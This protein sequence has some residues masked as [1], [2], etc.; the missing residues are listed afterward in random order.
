MGWRHRWTDC[1]VGT[2]II[3]R[4]LCL[5][6]IHTWL[7]CC[8]SLCSDMWRTLYSR[9][10]EK[11]NRTCTNICTARPP[12]L[13]TSRGWG[14]AK[15]TAHVS[16]AAQSSEKAGP[17]GRFN[18]HAAWY[19]TLSVTM[20]MAHGGID[21]WSKSRK[22]SAVSTLTLSRLRRLSINLEITARWW[23]VRARSSSRA[24]ARF[25]LLEQRVISRSPGFFCTEV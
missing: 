10:V 21:S 1:S 23:A 11:E 6:C 9:E 20:E 12:S 4:S 18:L 17:G 25:P 3:S 22:C 16:C 19:A 8:S 7:E 24:S 2:V 15:K 13:M 14:E 5:A